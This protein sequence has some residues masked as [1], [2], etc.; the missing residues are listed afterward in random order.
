MTSCVDNLA[1][2]YSPWSFTYVGLYGYGLVEAGQ[3]AS[4]LFDKRGWSTIVSD[5]LAPNVL[6]LT[7]LVIGG[8]TGLF[9]HLIENAESLALTTLGEPGLVSFL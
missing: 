6:L 4:D 5:D 7:S 3:S 2:R 1:D 8:V 9:T